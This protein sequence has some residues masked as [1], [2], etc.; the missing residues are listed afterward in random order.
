MISHISLFSSA[1]KAKTATHLLHNI[2]TI[3]NV[4]PPVPP[5]SSLQFALAYALGNPLVV[6]GSNISSI[7]Y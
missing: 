7:S 3:V 4:R 1:Y 2:I 6:H 5:S